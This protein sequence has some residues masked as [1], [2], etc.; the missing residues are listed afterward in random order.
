MDI[1]QENVNEGSASKPKRLLDRIREI[2]RLKHY[3]IR[4]EEAYIGWMVRLQVHPL[5][6]QRHPKDMGAPEIE[7]FQL[8]T[9]EYSLHCSKRS[10]PST[11]KKE[12]PKSSL[13]IL[14]I[15]FARVRH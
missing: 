11:E 15:L 4:T 6:Q 1:T 13:R 12:K 7:A 5:S 9:S 2:M 10:C 3:S 14:P 8:S